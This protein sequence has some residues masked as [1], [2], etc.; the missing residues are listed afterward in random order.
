MLHH[1]L[2]QDRV[3]LIVELR[4]QYEMTALR[5]SRQLN[6]TRSTV[7]A[8][9]HLNIPHFEG[10]ECLIIGGSPIFQQYIDGNTLKPHVMLQFQSKCYRDL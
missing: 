7:S 9:R 4:T 6:L 1:Q 10:P 2:G 3:D 8:L 5:I